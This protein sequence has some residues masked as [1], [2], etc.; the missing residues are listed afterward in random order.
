MLDATRV[1]VLLTAASLPFS[2]GA[3]NVFMALALLCWALSAKSRETYRAIAAEPAA[4]LGFAILGAL[5]I[6][7]AWSRVPAREAMATVLK[8]RELALFGMVMFLFAE[9]P[10]R[11]R[12]LGVFFIAALALV[13]G[14]FAIHV[15]LVH[16][17]VRGLEESAVVIRA[18]I[19]HAFIVSLLAYGA[20]VFALRAAGWR[21]WAMAGVAFLAALNVFVAVQGRTGYV[22]LIALA[23]W[24][25]AAQRSRKALVAVLLG[26]AI[27]LPAAYR[28]APTFQS[29]IDLTTAEAIANRTDHETSIAMRRH[30]L[31]RSLELIKKDPF[32]G[33][34]TGAWREAFYE[35]TA[36]DPPL[37]HNR[38]H[39]HPHS[40]YLHLGVQLGIGGL[41]LLV[42]LFGV[43]F[44]RAGAL[45]EKEALLARGLVLAFAVGCLFNDFLWDSTEGHLW[46]VLGGALFGA[47]AL[48]APA[49]L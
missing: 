34:G 30:Y 39:Y 31:K 40:E 15:G 5:C 16:H 24:L 38:R 14:S 42:A 12:L 33:A 8:Y 41:A 22:V 6:G 19:T 43:A 44:W 18:P 9:R 3:S 46:A 47:S 32:L 28:W 13:A 26:L 29:R 45:P 7:V 10:W 36:Y 11:A 17:V 48:R 37:F 21:R 49:R 20:A 1:A 4:W 2:T 35:A 25:A 27:A 23:L